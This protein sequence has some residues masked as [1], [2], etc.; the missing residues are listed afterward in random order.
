MSCWPSPPWGCCGRRNALAG[1]Q[2]TSLAP[3]LPVCNL[4]ALGLKLPKY[5]G[6]LQK[7]RASS[8]AGAGGFAGALA[9]DS[10]ASGVVLSCCSEDGDLPV[11]DEHGS[12]A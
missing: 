11:K 3:Y 7:G 5:L 9:A 8:R 2:C 4:L 10:K 12:F 6:V 1:D